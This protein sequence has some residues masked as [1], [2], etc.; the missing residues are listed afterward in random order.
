MVRTKR[1]DQARRHNAENRRIWTATVLLFALF[2]ELL[3]PFAQALAYEPSSGAEFQ[4]ICT[5][6]GVKQVRL[7][8]DA[9]P[10]EEHDVAPCPFCFLHATPVLLDLHVEISVAVVRV[11]DR[12]AFV[13]VSETLSAGIWRST[14]NPSRAPPL[15]V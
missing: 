10:V 11:A 1:P 5:V 8:E 2:V 4:V 12:I 9:T 15:N 7:D 6:G 3:T 13:P 14:P